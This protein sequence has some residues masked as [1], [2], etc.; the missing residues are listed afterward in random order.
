MAG[1]ILEMMW[2]AALG[3]DEATALLKKLATGL[4]GSRLTRE[5]RAAQARPEKAQRHSTP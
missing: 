2:V 3:G 5:A 1:S 4:P